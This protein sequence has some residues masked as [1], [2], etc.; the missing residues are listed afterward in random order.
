MARYAFEL[1]G[2]HQTIPRS[3]ALSLLEIYSSR[4]EEVCCLDQ[5]LIADAQDLNIRALEKR[6]AMTHRIIEVLDIC[7]ADLSAIEISAGSMPMPEGKYRI[8]AKRIKHAP[9]AADQVERCIGTALF[10]RGFRADLSSP[11]TELRAILTGDEAVIGTEVARVDRSS[12]EERRPHL[13]PFFHPGV[14]MPR[15]AR[16]LINM[17]R[18]RTGEVLLDPFSGTAGILVEAGLI[19]LVGLGI[20]VQKMLARGARSNLAGL[21]GSL[22]T[23]DAKRLPL[24]SSSIDGIVSDTPYGRSALIRADSR[25]DLLDQS[26]SEMCRVLRPGRRLAVIADRPIAD[27]VQKAGFIIAEVHTD[28]VHRSLTRHIYLCARNPAGS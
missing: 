4:Y 20:D 8:R 15:M 6:L 23:G 18:V 14:L 27:R 26:L 9:L 16:A 21:D 25:E 1:S 17:V 11:D 3:E 22:I 2:E 13:K 28:R 7:R 10:K 19:D 24:K 12:F 5:C